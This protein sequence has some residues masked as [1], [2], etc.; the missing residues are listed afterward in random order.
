MRSL[1]RAFDVLG[2]LQNAK[3]P[4]RLSE[5]ARHSA[6]HVATVQRILN[7]L[8]DRGYAARASDTYTAGPADLAVAHAFMVTNPLSLLAQ[9]TLQRLA[10][11]TGYTASL[12]VR[13]ENSRVLIARVESRRV[14]PR[15]RSRPAG[16]GRPSH[17]R[18]PTRAACDFVWGRRGSRPPPRCHPHLADAKSRNTVAAP[19]SVGLA[20]S[21]R[22]HLDLVQHPGSRL[23]RRTH[24]RDLRGPRQGR[25]A[26]EQSVTCGAHPRRPPGHDP[27]RTRSAKARPG[28]QCGPA[29][30]A[31]S[32]FANAATR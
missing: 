7:V 28:G 9:I 19:A 24:R 22:C 16:G 23:H 1:D 31:V 12:Y 10:A 26:G 15:R 2:V 25:P 6:L 4:L 11:S 27:R 8:V 5:V 30:G 18:E 13:V 14:L 21:D 20:V 17:P 32:R 3:Q 29:G